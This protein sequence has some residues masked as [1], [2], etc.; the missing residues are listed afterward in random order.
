MKT[1]LLTCFEPFDGRGLN[2]SHQLARL[3]AQN[4]S[5]G[6]NLEVL[7][8]PV[9][10]FRADAMVLNRLRQSPVDGVLMLGEASGRADITPELRA[11]N[12]DDYPIPDNAGNQPRGEPI[13]ADGPPFLESMLPVASIVKALKRAQIPAAPS[14]D[15]GTYLCN[16]VFYAVMHFLQSENRNIAAGFVHVPLLPVQAA[17]KGPDCPYLS[18]ETGVWALQIVMKTAFGR[19]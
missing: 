10:R 3:V 18:A 19:F 4:S 2:A 6:W 7:C 17:Q 11:V 8:L 15:A 1:L 12:L 5:F 9:E 16:R 14:Q 13:I